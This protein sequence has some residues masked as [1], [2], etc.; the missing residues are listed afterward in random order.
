MVKNKPVEAIR[1]NI[2]SVVLEIK[3]FIKNHKS[4]IALVS[5][6]LINLLIDYINYLNLF[7]E[8]RSPIKPNVFL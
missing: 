8:T 3:T 7:S 1:L 4:I 6:T 5:F 2:E